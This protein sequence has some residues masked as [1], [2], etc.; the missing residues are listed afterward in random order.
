[1]FRRF[2]IAVLIF[3]IAVLVAV[4]R[5]GAIV[6][7]HVLAGQVKT[8]EHLPSRPSASIGGFPFLTQAIGGKYKDVTI[9]ATNLPVDGVSVTSLTV[10]LHGVH[11]PLGKVIHDSVAQ[12]PVDRVDGTALVAFADLNNFLSSHHPLGQVLA[13]RPGAGNT[14]TV[15]ERLHV[16]S[17]VFSLHGVGT[18][19]L[20][21][22]VAHVSVAHL[23]GP[24]GGGAVSATV[25][26]QALKQLKISVPFGDLPFG[27][28]LTS[29]RFTSTGLTVAGG[30]ANTVLGASGD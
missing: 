1:V 16:G 30:A 23:A 19:S 29:V 7:A 18:I 28:A 4:D 11:V 21:G 6:A 9:E 12:V 15:F 17:K 5:L 8:D 25:L 27:I 3:L 10:H 2:L 26:R 20:D 13:L 22:N 24:R 14:A